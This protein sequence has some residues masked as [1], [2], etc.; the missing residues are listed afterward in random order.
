MNLH[1]EIPIGILRY[2]MFEIGPWLA[3]AMI[4]VILTLGTLLVIELYKSYKK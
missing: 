2:I 1:S 3:L 4:C